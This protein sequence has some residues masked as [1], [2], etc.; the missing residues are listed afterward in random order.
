MKNTL[1]MFA[2]VIML[3]ACTTPLDGMTPKQISGLS[4]SKICYWANLGDDVA[5]PE[6][7][8]RKLNCAQQN[9]QS[10]QP[11]QI[12]DGQIERQC[13]AAYLSNPEGF[14][15]CVQKQKYY[16]SNPSAPPIPSDNKRQKITCVNYG[17]QTECDIVNK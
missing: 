8:R 9:N 2:A 1:T 10:W 15:D 13:L 11:P 4:D 6:A 7:K 3:S 5:I 14:L 17:I 16:R 12:S